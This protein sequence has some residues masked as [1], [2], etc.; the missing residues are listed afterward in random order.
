MR[1]GA[2]GAAGD[3]LAFSFFG[4]D[5][6]FSIGSTAV[7]ERKDMTPLPSRVGCLQFGM[8]LV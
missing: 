5:F 7:R 3:L 2:F 8:V 1:S 6:G 4:A